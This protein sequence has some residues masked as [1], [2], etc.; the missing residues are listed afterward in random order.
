MPAQAVSTTHLERKIESIFTQA[1]MPHSRQLT[2]L[3]VALVEEEKKAHENKVLSDVVH[4]YA[5]Y[6]GPERN[7]SGLTPIDPRPWHKEGK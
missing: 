5:Q 4:Q 6:K 7:T 2:L 3:L 1:R